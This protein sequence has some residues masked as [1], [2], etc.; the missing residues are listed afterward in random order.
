MYDWCPH[1]FWS[2]PHSISGRNQYLAHTA[3]GDLFH[4][5][6]LAVKDRPIP[7][8][9]SGPC[10]DT[11]NTVHPYPSDQRHFQIPALTRPVEIWTP[12]GSCA[13]LQ[14]RFNYTPATYPDF[15][16]QVSRHPKASRHMDADRIQICDK[17]TTPTFSLVMCGL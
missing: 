12:T 7:L 8:V 2:S 1:R 4:C 9:I 11:Q 10:T 15:R 5:N 13:D 16:S 17:R 6:T 3:R 14:S